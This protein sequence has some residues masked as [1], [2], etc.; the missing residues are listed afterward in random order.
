MTAA[1]YKAFDWA[2]T[3]S[4]EGETDSVNTA[5]RVLINLVVN[6]V[7]AILNLDCRPIIA[8]VLVQ[9]QFRAPPSPHTVVRYLPH[10][11]LPNMKRCSPGQPNVFLA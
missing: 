10:P 3:V 9:V 2:M 11:S 4:I 8:R 6:Q 5:R 7:N 1:K